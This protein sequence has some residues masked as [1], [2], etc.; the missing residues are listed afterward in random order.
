MTIV[1][2]KNAVPAECKTIFHES[3]KIAAL[4]QSQKYRHPQTQ[5]DRL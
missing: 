3:S 5:A 1:F 4:C 2:M